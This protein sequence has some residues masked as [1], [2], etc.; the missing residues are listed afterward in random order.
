MSPRA[1][2]IFAA[3]ASF[4]CL[5]TPL[6]AEETPAPPAA[7]DERAGDK[8]FLLRPFFSISYMGLIAD[9]MNLEPLPLTSLGV[10]AGW[11]RVK[12]TASRKIDL[13][14]PDPEDEGTPYLKSD[15]FDLALAF[16]V[17]AK[18]RELVL[19]PFYSRATGAQVVVDSD[20]EPLDT[21]AD[22]LE[23]RFDISL[24]GFGLDTLYCLNPSFSYDDWLLELK[25]RAR[26]SAS[27]VLRSSVGRVD[28]GL[29]RPAAGR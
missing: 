11:G 23:D 5:P 19:T 4:A 21:R 7:D 22:Y 12:L 29:R 24:R 15:V 25:P 1:A 17:P 6:R 28:L 14:Q 27:V 8:P 10:S 20:V 2:A 9:E 26:S 3:I 13:A 18:G 16:S